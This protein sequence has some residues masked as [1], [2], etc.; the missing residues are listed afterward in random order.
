M[1][2]I[3]SL[4]LFICNYITGRLTR[5]VNCLVGFYD[6]IV[7]GISN[8]ERIST[9]ILFVLNGEEMNDEF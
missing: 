6:D 3:M 9:I 7:I 5:L 8:G 2:L 4:F 1:V